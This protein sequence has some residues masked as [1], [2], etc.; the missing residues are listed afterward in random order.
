MCDTLSSM[1]LADSRASG[2]RPCFGGSHLFIPDSIVPGC[3]SATEH[4][5]Q[6]VETAA[7][8]MLLNG[9]TLVL[10]TVRVL[11]APRLH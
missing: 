10:A 9:G 4:A 2:I 5:V 8:R 3:M 7:C 1:W 11:C 6:G